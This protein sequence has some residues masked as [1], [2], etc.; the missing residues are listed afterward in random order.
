MIR[1]RTVFVLGAGA[2]A[3]YGFPSGAKLA[4]EICR[5]MSTAKH[6]FTNQLRAMFGDQAIETFPRE[7]LR[8]GRIAR[9][10]HLW[11]AATS[12]SHW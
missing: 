11:N 10:T 7:F 9:W 5:R 6:P 8:S 2:S 1:K 4:D 3:A 12:S